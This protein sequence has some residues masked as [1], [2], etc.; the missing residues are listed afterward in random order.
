MSRKLSPTGSFILAQALP[1]AFYTNVLSVHGV[2]DEWRLVQARDRHDVEQRR[3]T[4]SRGLQP[5]ETA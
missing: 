4:N 1:S 2:P 5:T 3:F